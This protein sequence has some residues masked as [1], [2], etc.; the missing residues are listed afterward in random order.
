MENLFLLYNASRA[1]KIKSKNDYILCAL[2][3]G[4][5]NNIVKEVAVEK[6]EKYE[7]SLKNIPILSAIN[8]YE[9]WQICDAFNSENK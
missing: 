5:F 9:L 6:R 4:D 7:N 1:A 3:R 2:D 8:V